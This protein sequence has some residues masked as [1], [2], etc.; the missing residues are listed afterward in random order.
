[1]K[2]TKHNLNKFKTYSTIRKLAESDYQHNHIQ[3]LYALRQRTEQIRIHVNYF[4][5]NTS[6]TH[7]SQE[8]ASDSEWFVH[9]AL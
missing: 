7:V 3:N 6:G 2:I 8:A 4:H 5:N 1:M 9:A